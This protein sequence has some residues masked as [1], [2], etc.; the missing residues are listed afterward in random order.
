MSFSTLKNRRE[1]G[2]FDGQFLIAMPGMEDSNFFRTVVYI[3]AHSDAGAMGFVINRPQSLTFTDVLLHL[4]MIK[5]DDRIVLPDAC[6]ELPDPDRRA[7]GKRP[8]F[9]VAFGRLYQ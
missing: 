1:R 8:R 5:E 2:F 7:G 9:C 3:C 6:A 4:E